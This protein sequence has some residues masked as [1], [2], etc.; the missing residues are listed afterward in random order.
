MQNFIQKKKKTKT[1]TNVNVLCKPEEIL[2]RQKKKKNWG[3]TKVEKDKK[4]AMGGRRAILSSILFLLFSPIFSPFWR[5]WIVVDPERKWLGP[6]TFLSP[7]PSHPNTLPT[8][9]LSYFPLFFFS[10]LPKIHQ[11]KHSVSLCL[12]LFIWRL[13]AN[14]SLSLWDFIWDFIWLL[15]FI[16]SLY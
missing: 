11:S 5:D 10:I 3:K 12:T 2:S 7:S 1:K 13:K 16:L 6:T 8:H 4:L 15:S 14:E 9:F